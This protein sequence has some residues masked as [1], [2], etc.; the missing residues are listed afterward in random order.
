MAY[1]FSD[2]FLCLDYCHGRCL[3]LVEQMKEIY[4]F[5]LYSLLSLETDPLITKEPIK[6]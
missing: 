6:N 2:S 1:S 5:K 3:W 4:K